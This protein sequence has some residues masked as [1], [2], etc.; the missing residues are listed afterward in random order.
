LLIAAGCVAALV[1][2]RHGENLRRLRGGAE[3]R[4]E[5]RHLEHAAAPTKHEEGEG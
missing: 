1:L 4:F 3:L 2:G 5:R